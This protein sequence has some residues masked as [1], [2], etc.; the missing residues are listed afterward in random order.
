[1]IVVLTSLTKR[2]IHWYHSML[3]HPG[4]NRT[5]ETIGQH[6]YWPKMREQITT[7]V[8][9][10]TVCQTQKKQTKKYG[11]LPEKEV[12]AVPWDRLCVDLIGPYNIKSRVKGVT[13][14]PL[15]C[16]TMIDP[17]SGWFEIAQYD[18]KKSITGESHTKSP[19]SR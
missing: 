8:S 9:S 5:E 16:V 6:F 17:A 4:I 13:I 2:L 11:L 7:D 18:D 15:K 10:C 14:P 12:E 3:C 1:M 19:I